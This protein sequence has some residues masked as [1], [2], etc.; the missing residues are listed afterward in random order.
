MASDQNKTI[1]VCE[2]YAWCPVELDVL[3]MPGHGFKYVIENFAGLSLFFYYVQQPFISGY[4]FK[5]IACTFEIRSLLP[6]F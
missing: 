6:C 2:I 4:A 5:V 3:P 1:N